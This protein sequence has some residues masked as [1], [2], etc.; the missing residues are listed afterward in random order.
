[1]RLRA[2]WRLRRRLIKE[3]RADE[4]DGDSGGDAEPGDQFFGGEIFREG[5][6]HEAEDEDAD[7]MGERDHGAEERGLLH[8]A[9]RADQISRDH[10]FAVAGRFR[11]QGSE[12]E[13]DSDSDEH[14]V[15]GN[16]VLAEHAGEI[17]ATGDFAGGGLGGGGGSGRRGLSERRRGLL[18][19]NDFRDEDGGFDVPEDGG[20]EILRRGERGVGGIGGEG[21]TAVSGGLAGF[22]DGRAIGGG[23]DDFLPAGA[24]GIVAIFEGQFAGDVV[25]A[26]GGFDAGRRACLRRRRRV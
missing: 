23:D 8:G 24:V 21:F 13:G 5:E 17:I 25:E 26:E 7:G 16:V 3:G 19:G 9:A 15:E 14:E 18:D 10:G 1:M 20:A 6:G 22:D 12:G 11:V 2:C 4:D